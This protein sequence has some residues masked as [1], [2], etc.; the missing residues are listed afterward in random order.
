MLSETGSDHLHVIAKEASRVAE[1]S[2]GRITGLRTSSYLYGVYQELADFVSGTIWKST[3]SI[4]NAQEI[5]DFHSRP[6]LDMPIVP[7]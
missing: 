2:L 4:P 1:L 5:H 6:S 7:A 3:E